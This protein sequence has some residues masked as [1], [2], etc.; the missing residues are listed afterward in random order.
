MS[1]MMPIIY[2]VTE[3]V[4]TL[5]EYSQVVFVRGGGVGIVNQVRV[6]LKDISWSN[7]A[8]SV[9]GASPRTPRLVFFDLADWIRRKDGG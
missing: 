3:R 4:K 8:V 2:S 9:I 7:M 6:E 1:L 5:F